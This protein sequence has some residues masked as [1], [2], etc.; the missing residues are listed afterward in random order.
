MEIERDS[1][2]VFLSHYTHL[3]MPDKTP[4]SRV[5]NVNPACNTFRP[6]LLMGFPFMPVRL[7][8]FCCVCW[9]NTLFSQ[10]FHAS[11]DPL[12]VR[13]VQFEQANECFIYF[14]NP[15]GDSLRLRWR[16]IES[17]L[18]E[19][20]D[21]DICD[22]GLCYIGIPPN[23]L[24]STVYDT[25]RPYIKLIVQP[26][27]VPGATWIWFRV[28]EEGNTAN[29]VDVFFSLHTPGTLH[30]KEPQ[31]S[32]LLA[33]PNPVSELLYIENK[34]ANTVLARLLSPAGQTRWQGSIPPFS[35]QNITVNN[36]PPGVYILQTG[37]GIQKIIV[38]PN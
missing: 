38:H 4:H 13:E 9:S 29:F 17:N 18:P 7:L 23:G 2:G 16:L 5:S 35:Q 28:N 6:I 11:P 12:L 1:G 37:A 26:D 24:M 3:S 15:S 20:W 32:T 22:Y 19:G 30:A 36:W 33:F 27:T 8:L 21:A 34:Q 14:D 10:T 31:A 25:I